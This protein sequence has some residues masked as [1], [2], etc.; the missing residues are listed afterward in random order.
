M[1]LFAFPFE[2]RLFRFTRTFSR[3]LVEFSC[4]PTARLVKVSLDFSD[5]EKPSYWSTLHS[6]DGNKRTTRWHG[7]NKEL[8]LLVLSRAIG[9]LRNVLADDAKAPRYIE[10]VPTLGYRFIAYV[11]ERAELSQRVVHLGGTCRRTRNRTAGQTRRFTA[12]SGFS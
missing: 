4:I 9:Q 11:E 7:R 12:I 2:A 6:E 10:T 1:K 8:A 5:G 3:G